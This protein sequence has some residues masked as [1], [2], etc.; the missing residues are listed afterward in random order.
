M[1]MESFNVEILTPCRSRHHYHAFS[2]TILDK[3]HC[4]DA[5]LMAKMGVGKVVPC[6]RLAPIRT[7][8]SA[9]NPDTNI[10]A[11]PHQSFLA[12]NDPNGRRS[13]YYGTLEVEFLIRWYDELI[14][15]I[16]RLSRPI[17]K[18]IQDG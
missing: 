14:T 15:V 4:R 5:L 17:A 8:F 7:S 1:E 12:L 16:T 2:K 6:A 11:S 9:F 18:S 3:L 13:R 10:L